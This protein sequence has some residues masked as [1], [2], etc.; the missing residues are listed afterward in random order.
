M[1]INVSDIAWKTA[2]SAGTMQLSVAM[3][4]PKK[5]LVA[6]LWQ[7]HRLL[8]G[9]QGYGKEVFRRQNLVRDGLIEQILL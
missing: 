8:R 7:V 6:A 4:P 1:L 3:L 9:K 5:L 2:F